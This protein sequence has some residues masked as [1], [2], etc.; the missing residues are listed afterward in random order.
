MMD[1]DDNSHAAMSVAQRRVHFLRVMRK[2]NPDTLL[3]EMAAGLEV[4]QW[5]LEAYLTGGVEMPEEV[6]SRIGPWMLRRCV[7]SM[8]EERRLRPDELGFLLNHFVA[9]SAAAYGVE[10]PEP[11][12]LH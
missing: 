3:T 12:V 11:G 10:L 7:E 4:T 2:Y 9:A 6:H 1:E 8:P 5:D